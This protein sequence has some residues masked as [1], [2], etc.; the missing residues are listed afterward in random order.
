MARKTRSVVNPMAMNIHGHGAAF[1]RVVSAVGSLLMNLIDKFKCWVGG[2]I[3]GGVFVRRI[4][5]NE[6]KNKSPEIYD[7][8][9]QLCKRCKC[10][11]GSAYLKVEK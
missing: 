8:S 11:M 7:E 2:H 3:D 1:T 5:I 10:L 6:K 4:E 9:R